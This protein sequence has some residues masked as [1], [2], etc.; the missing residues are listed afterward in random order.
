[1]DIYL[2]GAGEIL[3]R[4]LADISKGITEYKNN[5]VFKIRGIIDTDVSKSGKLISG[6]RIFS[7]DEITKDMFD[8]IV[9]TN[10]YYDEIKNDACSR[11]NVGTDKIK[12]GFFLIKQALLY[13][14]RNSTD[15]EIIEVLNYLKHNDLSMYN[16]FIKD[17]SRREIVK[18]DKKLNL[19]YIDFFNCKGVSQKMYYPREF[20][21]EIQENNQV[22]D[23]LSYEQE[24]G[25]PHL[26]CKG[27]H[28]IKKGDVIVDAGV[29]EGNFSLKYADIASKLYLFEPDDVWEEANYYTFKGY[30]DKIVFY[31]KFLSDIDDESNVSLDN[32]LFKKK[33]DFIKMDIEG[34]EE[35]ALIGGMNT[36]KNNN[37][38]AS[39]CTYHRKDDSDIV[40]KLLT[41]IGYNVAFS[42]GVV[43]F[44]W[45]KEIW[46]TLDFRK[47]IAYAERKLI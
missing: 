5:E 15:E 27:M 22:V 18:W 17:Q 8:Y 20:K 34:A 29:C 14:Y 30:K 31:R 38:R 3:R 6:L 45:D 40:K 12:T 39:I 4:I 11:Y 36:L 23:A 19:P 26:Y 7:P 44:I 16:N 33:V 28:S 46:K 47:C 25:S 37:I 10:S 41:E 42:R 2:W 1:M 35:K 32:V 9:V 21:F 43:S 13:K 24:E